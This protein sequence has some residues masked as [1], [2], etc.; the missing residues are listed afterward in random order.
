MEEE[1]MPTELQLQH[2]HDKRKPMMQYELEEYDERNP[3][4]QELKLKGTG[5]AKSKRFETE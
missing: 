2:R 5:N 4:K 1:L 3:H